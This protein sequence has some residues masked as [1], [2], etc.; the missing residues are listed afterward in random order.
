MLNER[1]RR[2][3]MICSGGTT[4]T[5]LNKQNLRFIQILFSC[6][7]SSYGYQL[8]I[9]TNNK[10]RSSSSNSSRNTNMLI[11]LC[12]ML[13]AGDTGVPVMFAW[14][15]GF[16][17]WYSPLR[18]QLGWNIFESQPHQKSKSWKQVSCLSRQ[19]QRLSQFLY[20]LLS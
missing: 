14:K 15:R 8:A 20:S 11:F 4:F 5:P 10:L 17:S 16:S 19:T 6:K 18:F 1:K 2:P 3:T 7:L 9:R 12:D 13:Q